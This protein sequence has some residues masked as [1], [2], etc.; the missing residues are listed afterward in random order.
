[1]PTISARR[2]AAQ[3]QPFEDVLAP[4]EDPPQCGVSSLDRKFI[5]LAGLPPPSNTA[6]GDLANFKIKTPCRN[7]EDGRKPI[8][9]ERCFLR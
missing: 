1:L 6:F 4:K 9:G 3:P 8:I 7:E 5:L 2:N